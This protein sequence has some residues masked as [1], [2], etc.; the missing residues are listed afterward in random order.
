MVDKEPAS[1]SGPA[2]KYSR[3]ISA[4][5][6]RR[7]NNDNDM[8]D[9]R[10]ERTLYRLPGDARRS[11]ESIVEEP[12]LKPPEIILN[13]RELSKDEEDWN[14]RRASNLKMQS[15]IRKRLL[16]P[17]NDVD[18]RPD[19]RRNSLLTPSPLTST[20]TPKFFVNGETIPMQNMPA[21]GSN[22]VDSSLSSTGARFAHIAKV[23]S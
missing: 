18:R 9:E 22:M 21:G 20:S 13:P 2:R 1:W 10:L 8:M 12:K 15:I 16:Q 11:N 19:E 14:R 17:M 4:P 5:P 3:V 7:S 6:R 23:Q